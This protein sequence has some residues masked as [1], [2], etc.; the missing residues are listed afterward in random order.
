MASHW[1]SND[2]F[3]YFVLPSFL[4]DPNN[5]NQPIINMTNREIVIDLE[6]TTDDTPYV[7]DW[8]LLV[9]NHDVTIRGKG[10]KKTRLVF[11]KTINM[12]A[13]DAVFNF[14]GS[15]GNEI[16]VKI[17]DLSIESEVNPSDISNDGNRLTTRDTHVIKCYHVKSFVMKNVS[18]IAK[19]IKT[20]CLDIRRGFNI[21]ICHCSFANYNRR[22][23]G[24]NVWLRGDLENV[25]IS[26]CDF[27]KYGEDELISIW[28]SNNFQG[29][30]EIPD[31][32]PSNVNEIHKKNIHI[33]HNR[34]FCQDENGG[35]NTSAIIPE[36]DSTWNGSIERL[37][38]IF[39]NQ[40]DNTMKVLVN[41][42]YVSV[43][44]VIPCSYI[45][46]DI[47]ISNNEIYINAP[48]AHLLTIALDKHTKYK[49][50]AIKDNVIKYGNWQLTGSNS[51]YK[52]LVDFN[53]YYDTL[54][55]YSQILGDYDLTSD[56]PFLISGN[57]IICGCN[58][59][60]MQT[61]N[62][63]TYPVDNHICLD[64]NGVVV[65]FHGN[66]INYTRDAYSEDESHSASKGLELF[67][68]SE[69]GGTLIFNENFCEG[70]KLLLRAHKTT[71]RIS[72]VKLIGR[73]NHFQGNPRLIYNNVDESHV[74][75][76][77]NEFICDYQLLLV[78]EFA[79]TGTVVF[80]SNRILRDL[81]RV[82]FY[83]EPK[84]QLFYTGKTNSTSNITSM[85]FICCNNIFENLIYSSLLYNNFQIVSTLKA[86]HKN[87]L[88]VDLTE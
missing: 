47:Q 28:G 82:L 84:G 67:N 51:D 19:N 4:E 31:W 83:T 17:M 53:I 3:D 46:N 71:S 35:L 81:S 37:I 65:M 60:N 69:K 1:L 27:Y 78:S 8:N 64:I 61:K 42:E 59:R 75:L 56:E 40:D 5:G 9:H 33:S 77:G 44:R 10:I 54:Y 55:D 80:T 30:N 45:I 25:S 85:K 48:I 66:L 87:N 13:D 41:E 43:P 57:S 15:F 22:C 52:E 88:F 73:G 2:L 14:K 50:I 36:G 16:S 72:S 21:D 74:T 62:G 11:R 58:V 70:L 32:V 23:A 12:E 86:I 38:T 34:I 76:I 29:E 63:Q 6:E 7:I 18:I 49:E 68:A 20:T 79:D 26:H 24:G 39:T